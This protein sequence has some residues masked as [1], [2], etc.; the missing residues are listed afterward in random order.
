MKLRPRKQHPKG[1]VEN[2]L[3][4]DLYKIIED[5]RNTLKRVASSELVTL[6]WKI[7]TEL[8]NLLNKKNETQAD[9]VIIRTISENLSTKYGPYF[10]EKSLNKMRLFADTFHDFIELQQYIHFLSWE[11]LLVLLKLK[12]KDERDFYLILKI[13]QGL[14]VKELKMEIALNRYNSVINSTFNEVRNIVSS[15]KKQKTLQVP[16]ITFELLV[17]NDRAKPNLF[18]KSKNSVFRYLLEP[19]KQVQE[20]SHNLVHHQSIAQLVEDYRIRQNN[21]LNANFNLFLWEVGKRISQEILSKKQ[22]VG[23]NSIMK[24]V[25]A[26]FQRDGKVFSHEQQHLTLQFA[27][28][29]PTLEVA[30]KISYLV[31]WEHLVIL[32]SLQDINEFF[33]YIEV[34]IESGINANELRKLIS[35]IPIEGSSNAKHRLQQL[36]SMGRT[37]NKKSTSKKTADSNINIRTIDIA[38]KYEK[39]FIPNVFENHFFQDFVTKA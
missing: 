26:Q 5:R 22:K 38:F 30:S 29:F 28:R 12:K 35:K 17:K 18:K 20:N 39:K 24:S 32:F 1:L 27:E 6:F 2:Q 14:S 15:K 10:T 37:Y 33:F 25:S 16:D 19:T 11:H 13:K 3:I 23:L 4:N 21:W 34:V 7:G 8:N 9:K 31:S 36:L